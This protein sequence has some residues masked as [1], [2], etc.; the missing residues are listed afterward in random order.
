MGLVW[1][2][3]ATR[4][5]IRC[6]RWVAISIIHICSTHNHPATCRRQGLKLQ[7][8]VR[9]RSDWFLYTHETR[10]LIVGGGTG[11]GGGGAT[12]APAAAA[13]TSAAAAAAAA[14]AASPVLSSWQFTTAGV[15]HLPLF[16]LHGPLPASAAAREF[17]VNQ[18]D[19]LAGASVVL[20]PRRPSQP[21]RTA[22]SPGDPVTPAAPSAPPSRTASSAPSDPLG[23]AAAGTGAASAAGQ[24]AAGVWLLRMYG[25]VYLAH[26]ARRGG[27]AQLELYRFY[28][29]TLL[30]ERIYDLVSPEVA[31][32]VVDSCLLIHYASAAV[33][34]LADVALPGR[35]PLTS[36]LPL[37]HLYRLPTTSGGGAGGSGGGADGGSGLSYGSSEA[38]HAAGWRYLMP[39]LILNADSHQIFRLH[40]DLAAISDSVSDWPSLAGFLMRRRASP[41]AAALASTAAAPV[42]AGTPSSPTLGVGGVSA[43]GGGA[44]AADPADPRA[45]LLAVCRAALQEPLELGALRKI[46][47]QLVQAYAD[48]LACPAGGGAGAGGG[49]RY[50]AAQQQQAPGAHRDAP[51]AVSVLSPKELSE[52]LFGWAHD[53]EVVDALYLQV[54][55]V[56]L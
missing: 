45:L 34:V 29:D 7:Q 50:G 48:V 4:R 41:V 53:E 12:A 11:G 38:M 30:L 43:A 22:A 8:R 32:S 37:R 49:A 10:M 6:V 15:L 5:M 28:S 56:W 46:F 40:L 18:P 9:R 1:G 39:N 54:G 51:A 33:A 44:A 20:S 25:R 16:E 24:R 47:R 3:V 17:L 35:Q 14:A 21:P 26:V 52:A 42:A 27:G 36:P 31:L 55:L 2:M 19:A 13:V 23:P